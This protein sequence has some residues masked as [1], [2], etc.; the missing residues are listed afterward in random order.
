MF[1]DVSEFVGKFLNDE[2]DKAKFLIEAIV[3]TEISYLFTNDSEY[4]EN[5]TTFIPK[6]KAGEKTD[7]K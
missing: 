1:N 4:M 6:H 7:T 5:Y 3:K 2:R